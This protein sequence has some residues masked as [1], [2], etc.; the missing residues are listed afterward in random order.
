MKKPGIH[1]E[2]TLNSILVKPAGPDC[3]MACDYC[4]YR[5]KGALFPGAPAHRMTEE[6]LEE[7]V[8]QVLAQPVSAVSFGWQGGEPTLMGLDFFR[9]A[10]ALEVRHG[11]G[12]SVANGLQTN[13]LLIDE[14]WADFLREYRFLVGLSLD[15]PEHVH[16]RYRHLAGGR[17]TW[18]KTMDAAGLL[19][20]SEVAV[21]AL[22]VVNDYSA[23]F[24]AEIYEF[25]KSLGLDHMQFIPCVEPDPRDPGRAAPFSAAGPDFGKFLC[26][27]F[28][29]WLD[30]FK[31]GEPTT[32]IRYF[33]SLFYR[34]VDREP[35]ECDLLPECGNYLVV[36][37]NGDV[38]ACDFFVEERWKLGNVMHGKLVH[39]LN[40]ARQTEFG[41]M[42]GGLP[43]ACRSCEWIALCRGGCTK[44]RLRDPR[45]RGLN[46]FCEGYKIFF[47]RADGRLRKLAEAWKKK[48][49]AG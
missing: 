20:D 48:N 17:K 47:A 14:A 49:D 7:V 45:D 13:G 30:D 19:L 10:V 38:F 34:Y 9:K 11:R 32:F 2:K 28:D 15:G 39:M 22:V 1:K 40:S 42:K 4:F 44:D 23:R 18:Q 46:H 33:D 21:N 31:D 12:K 26:A 27:V 24:P 37:H 29:R 36:E 16:N 6:I 43:D 35:P 25:H 5:E 8:R 41:R 3:N